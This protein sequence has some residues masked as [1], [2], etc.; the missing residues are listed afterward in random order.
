MGNLSMERCGKRDA[1]HRRGFIDIIIIITRNVGIA[2]EFKTAKVLHRNGHRDL[3]LFISRHRPAE[4]TLTLAS[5]RSSYSFLGL[6]FS[7]TLEEIVIDY[8]RNIILL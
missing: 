7:S 5:K 3:P 1:I 4:T 6:R 8:F 2:F